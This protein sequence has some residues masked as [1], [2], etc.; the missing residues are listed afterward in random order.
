MAQKDAIP[1]GEELD[2]SESDTDALFA[3]PSSRL[4]PKR[5]SRTT[6]LNSQEG[7]R[8]QSHASKDGEL[9]DQEARKAALHKELAGLRTINQT[10]EGAIDGLERARSNMD[11]WT[12]ILS[13]T[14]HNQRLILDPSWRGASQDLADLEN[15]SVLKQQEKE[16]RDLEET[17]RREARARR[18]EEDERRKAE[19]AG[20]KTPRGGRNRGRGTSRGA[21]ASREWRVLETLSDEALAAIVVDREECE[22]IAR[23]RVLA[24]DR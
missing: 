24:S 10:I 20:T 13:Q 22:K 12:R 6:E 2:L 16:R 7:V 18:A 9:N 5:R 15:E 21:A 3:S 23:Q 19:N 4:K 11:T 8:Q 1:D 14:E 17:Q